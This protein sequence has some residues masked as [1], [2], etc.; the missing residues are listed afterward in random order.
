MP[1]DALLTAR[2]RG[3]NSRRDSSVR[4]RACWPR[5]VLRAACAPS[6]PICF[7][8]RTGIAVEGFGALSEVRCIVARDAREQTLRTIVDLV[9]TRAGLPRS[10][11]AR[12]TYLTQALAS[13]YQVMLVNE[14]RT[15]PDMWQAY[16][17]PAGDRAAAC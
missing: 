7:T 15:A 2:R 6:S 9:S 4:S 14:S 3:V 8:W 1:D 13:V 10:V 5:P 17:F 12:K 16:E 11:H